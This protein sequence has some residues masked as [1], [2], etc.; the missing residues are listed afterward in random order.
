MVLMKSYTSRSA[1]MQRGFEILEARRTWI[2]RGDMIADG[3]AFEVERK[4]MLLVHFLESAR[5]D[6]RYSVI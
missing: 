5:R 4:Y 2:I 3:F 1:N 6:D